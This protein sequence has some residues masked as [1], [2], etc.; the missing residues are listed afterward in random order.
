M[1]DYLIDIAYNEFP[2]VK[3]LVDKVPYSC[4][5]LHIMKQIFNEPYNELKMME[6]IDKNTF[7]SLT[8][9]KRFIQKAKEGEL[10]YYGYYID[11]E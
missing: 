6:Y 9:K 5:N 1:L 10:T 11:S 4:P 8:W 3:E 2:L 7:F